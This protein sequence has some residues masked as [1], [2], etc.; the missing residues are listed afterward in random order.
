[1]DRQVRWF[2][3]EI[4]IGVTRRLTAEAFLVGALAV[5]GSILAGSAP[6][7][8]AV[9]GVLAMVLVTF[10]RFGSALAANPTNSAYLIGWPHPSGDTIATPQTN[11]DS[12]D[13]VALRTYGFTC[14]GAFEEWGGSV[15]NVYTRDSNQIIV[16]T[17]EDGD[18]I[19]LSGIDHD[20]FVVTTKQLIPPHERLIVNQRRE[21]DVRSILASHIDLMKEQAAAGRA[22]RTVRF[23]D[24]LELLAI[25][26]DSWDQ[27]GPVLGPFVAVGHRRA[28]SVLQVRVDATYILERTS[29]PKPKITARRAPVADAHAKAAPTPPPIPTEV[30]TPPPVH[31]FRTANVEAA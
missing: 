4:A 18:L 15:T 27:I 31:V 24:V 19:A 30:V 13:D 10:T 29:E 11:A 7:S 23:H 28:P 25:E 14:R 8:A 20:Q 16:T 12:P 21:T 3:R 1:M 26:W 22:V 5:G 6:I 9:A 17:S 2:R